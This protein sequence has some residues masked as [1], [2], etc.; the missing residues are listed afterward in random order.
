MEKR[1]RGAFEKSAC[2]SCGIVSSWLIL[3]G[4]GQQFAGAGFAAAVPIPFVCLVAAIWL[5]LNAANPR[6]STGSRWALL[7]DSVHLGAILAIGVAEF[8]MGGTRSGDGLD[9][10]FMFIVPIVLVAACRQFRR[11]QSTGFWIGSVM[12]GLAIFLSS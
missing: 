2:V 10:F 7:S 11:G 1:T 3:V 12:F 5:Y 9:T 6:R 4:F 8:Y